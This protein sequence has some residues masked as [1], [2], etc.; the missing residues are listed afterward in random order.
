MDLQAMACLISN[1]FGL[2][3]DNFIQLQNFIVL[4]GPF[5]NLIQEY[6]QKLILFYLQ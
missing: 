4:M 3:P 2:V 6:F 5:S 1:L